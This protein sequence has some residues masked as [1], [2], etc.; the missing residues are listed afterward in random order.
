MLVL[1]RRAG[2][3]FYL[4][5][6]I[7]ITIQSIKGDGVRVAIDAPKEVQILRSELKEAQDVNREAVMPQA[8]AI[9]ALR[10]SLRKDK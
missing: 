4:G 3:S 5:D 7:K 6:D 10:K 1:T 2:E 8:S 9:E